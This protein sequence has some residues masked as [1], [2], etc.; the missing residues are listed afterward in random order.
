MSDF[1]TNDT[2]GFGGSHI[3]GS[4]NTPPRPDIK[5]KQNK[6]KRQRLRH[7]IDYLS[8]ELQDLEREKQAFL[9]NKGDID[10]IKRNHTFFSVFDVV[11]GGSTH[12]L[13]GSLKDAALNKKKEI[14]DQSDRFDEKIQTIKNKINEKQQQ[15]SQL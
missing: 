12:P 7:E 14:I 13:L 4:F 2:I 8:R 10:Q 9:S 15:L 5:P 1:D 6:K 11:Q 3:Q